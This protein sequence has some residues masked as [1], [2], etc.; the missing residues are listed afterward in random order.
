VRQKTVAVRQAAGQVTGETL[1]KLL[2]PTEG[3]GAATHNRRLLAMEQKRYPPSRV[4]VKGTAPV[5]GGL[6]GKGMK[7]PTQAEQG[8]IEPMKHP[9]ARFGWAT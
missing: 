6:L 1:R 3:P 2:P 5:P 8:Q 7:R 4:T 9:Q